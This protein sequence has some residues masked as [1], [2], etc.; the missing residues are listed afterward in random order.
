[1]QYLS[2]SISIAHGN[3]MHTMWIS[4]AHYVDITCKSRTPSLPSKVNMLIFLQILN[5][6]NT[7]FLQVYI[8]LMQNKKV[9]L[10][11]VNRADT[12]LFMQEH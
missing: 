9:Y 11:I 4:H 7:A 12:A 10:Q 3:H 5:I 2:T 6:A 1:M 8:K